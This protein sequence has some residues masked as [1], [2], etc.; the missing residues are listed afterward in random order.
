M[1]LIIHV[2]IFHV[3]NFYCLTEHQNFL[4]ETFANYGICIHLAIITENEYLFYYFRVR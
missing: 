2:K 4:N 3:L 1:L